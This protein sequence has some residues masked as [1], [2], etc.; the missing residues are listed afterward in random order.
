M[1]ETTRV[2]IT[3]L[4]AISASGATLDESWMA[5]KN[6]EHGITELEDFDISGWP[7]R[8]GGQV[9]NYKPAKMLPDKKLAKVISKQDVIG[10]NA[11]TQAVEHS[12]LQQWQQQLEDA[13]AFNDQT[14]V[15][16][17]S[18]GNKFLQQYDFLP[19]M[20]KSEGNMQTFAKELFSEVHPMWL[21]RILPNNVLAYTGITYGFKGMNH[22]ITNHAVSG[23]QAVIE[24]WHAIR[25][26][27][28]ERAVVVAYDLGIEPQ[29][30]IYYD[31]LGLISDDQLRPFD[32]KQSGTLL[33]DGA[34]AIILESEASANERN[35]RR[36]AEVLGGSVQTEAS[37]LLSIEK[38]G[39]AL[40]DLIQKSLKQAALAVEDLGMIVAH[41]NGNPLSDNSEA[42][43]FHRIGAANVPVTGFK[44]SYGHSLCASG[45]LDT[46]HAV[47]ALNEKLIPGIAH[48]DKASEQAEG[49]KISH[50][51]QTMADKNAALIVNRG[52]GSMNANLVIKACE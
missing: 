32:S 18:P 50:Q 22:N 34:A 15:F 9:K 40:S 35:A 11:A 3:G 19:L 23:V 49:L 24:A 42:K 33:A 47:K 6:G 26:G 28:A 37:G 13:T 1:T 25:T 44:W 30:L 5:L 16:V 51:H 45:L 31:K 2:F 7:R 10:I 29:G 12:G 20:A 43:A 36:Y 46:V 41:G 38:E 17:G 27:R 52:F 4:G 48:F 21:L 14:A 39:E 8:K